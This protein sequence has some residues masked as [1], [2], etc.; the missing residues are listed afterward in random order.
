[1][2][3]TPKFAPHSAQK[4]GKGVSP[5]DAAPEVPLIESFRAAIS[6]YAVIDPVIE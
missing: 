3:G 2:L 5:A 1:M 6:P 4:I